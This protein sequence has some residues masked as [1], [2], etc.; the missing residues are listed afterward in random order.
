MSRSSKDYLTKILDSINRILNVGFWFIILEDYKILR[1]IWV[2][3]V[4]PSLIFPL[5]CIL[6]ELYCL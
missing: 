1:E 5:L 6:K 3:A 4:T 2:S